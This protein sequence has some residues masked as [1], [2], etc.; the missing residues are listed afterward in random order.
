LLACLAGIGLLVA[1]TGDTFSTPPAVKP[2]PVVEPECPDGKCPKRPRRPWGPR[3][4]SVEETSFVG[5]RTFGGEGV[6]CDFPP[7]LWMENIGSRVDGAGMCV[8]TSVEML[9]RY[10]SM[11][12]M[13]GFRDFCAK[14]P[15]GCEPRKLEDQLGRFC[16][17]KNT[18][19]PPY[20]NFVGV[21]PTTLLSDLDAAGLPYAHTY[22]QCPRYV[23]WRN[24]TG[25]IA[26]MVFSVKY[27]NRYAVVVDNNAIGG[28][29]PATGA[30]FEW[31]SVG[32]EI[33][34]MKFGDDS[35]WVFAFLVPPP[36]PCP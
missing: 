34:R 14:E 35:A 25:K 26:H 22:G 31:M 18:P 19:I 6:T 3:G 32:E 12:Q 10:L 1:V 15:G 2:A 17:A 29:D 33:R 28:V 11:Y 5:G 36:P 20:V 4:S 30:I 21:D 7:S 27:C 24:P 8:S 16:K 13:A 23:N 9:A